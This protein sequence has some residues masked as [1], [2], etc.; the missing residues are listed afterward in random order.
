MLLTRG[1]LSA[2]ISTAAQTA[3]D[4]KKPKDFRW[5]T[6][7]AYKAGEL[8]VSGGQPYTAVDDHTSGATFGGDSAHWTLVVPGMEITSMTLTTTFAVAASAGDVTD[9][10]AG[11]A[12]WQVVC[13]ANMGPISVGIDSVLLSIVTGTNASGTA[14][15]LRVRILDE[16][17]TQVG[18]FQHRICSS[19]ATSQTWN[20][21]KAARFPLPNNASQKTYRVQALQSLV[22]TNSSTASI[23]A[24]AAT[25][26]V[27]PVLSVCRR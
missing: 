5:A 18:A 25:D 26:V 19:L 16:A 15:A 7:V 9:A 20:Q 4:L 8:V 6:G 23:A 27:P 12:V 21:S 2:P 11:S 22:G 10:G 1:P 17:N 13:P 24:T 14:F 3:L